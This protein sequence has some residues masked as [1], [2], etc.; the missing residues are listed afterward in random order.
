MDL[1]YTDIERQLAEALP[2]LTPAAHCYW[3]KEGEPREDPG[4]YLFFE[5]MF[6]FYVRIL[7]AM[8]GSAGRNR[9]LQRAFDFVEMMLASADT[10]IQNLAYIGLFEGQPGWWLAEAE[11]FLGPRSIGVLD[12]YDPEWRVNKLA[13]DRDAEDRFTD[14]YGVRPVIA[15]ELEL[16]MAAIP[17]ETV[18]S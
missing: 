11:R 17:G 7:L 9:L 13:R 1:K 5:D 6:G 4:P 8:P 15:A 16:G 3:R 12:R 2:E 14:L 10:D 18:P